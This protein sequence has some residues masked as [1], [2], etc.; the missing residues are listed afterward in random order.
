[1][2]NKKCIFQIENGKQCDGYSIDNSDFC[3]THDPNS[4]ERKREATSK[5][6]KK[7][8]IR[9]LQSIDVNDVSDIPNLLAKTMQ[10]VRLGII[11]TQE[12][13]AIKKLADSYIQFYGLS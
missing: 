4:I 6:G 13:S 5:G 12:A 7:K 8:R 9:D 2:P 10:E 1:M 3:F 11:S